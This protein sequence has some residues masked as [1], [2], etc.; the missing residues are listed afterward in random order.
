M[1]LGAPYNSSDT[2]T[3]RNIFEPTCLPV[4]RR[5][6]PVSHR[7]NVSLPDAPRNGVPFYLQ[8]RFL[9]FGLCSSHRL[10]KLFWVFV[11]LK[12]RGNSFRRAQLLEVLKE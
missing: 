7:D 12:I 4:H 11:S 2:N 8:N 1:R 5:N 9:P 6:T 10:N 3:F